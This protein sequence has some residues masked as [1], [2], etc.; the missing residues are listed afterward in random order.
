[1]DALIGDPNRRE[2]TCLCPQSQRR[3]LCDAGII[4]VCSDGQFKMTVS[5]HITLIDIH[6]RDAEPG[7]FEV[8][9]II[10]ARIMDE[11]KACWKFHSK[12]TNDRSTFNDHCL[13]DRNLI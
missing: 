10:L 6:E 5:V 3:A 1:M 7:R 13:N 4:L 11:N 2:P 9:T 8:M 12:W